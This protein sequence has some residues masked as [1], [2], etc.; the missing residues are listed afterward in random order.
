MLLPPVGNLDRLL[1]GVLLRIPA[2]PEAE[3]PPPVA[4]A[5]QRGLVQWAC[6]RRYRELRA[7]HLELGD[8]PHRLQLSE[9]EIRQGSGVWELGI[10][11]IGRDG[12]TDGTDETV[13]V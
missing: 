4:R 13:N 10:C 5:G 11:V 7:L 1:V 9:Q 6:E 3:Q 12:R 2:P 8:V